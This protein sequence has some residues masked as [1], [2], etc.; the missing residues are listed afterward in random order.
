M[1]LIDRLRNKAQSYSGAFGKT[2]REAADTIEQLQA[3][4]EKEEIDS[5]QVIGERDSYHE[6][7]DRLANGIGV[8]LGIEIGEHSSMNCPWQNALEAISRP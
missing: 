3:E 4:A 8:H 2:L 7:A 1:N 5:T 6:T